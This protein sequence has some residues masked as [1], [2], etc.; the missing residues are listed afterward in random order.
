MIPCAVHNSLFSVCRLRC[1]AQCSTAAENWPQWRGPLG[2][3]VAAE[4]EYPVKFS[5]TESVAW[6]AKLPG[7]GTSTPAVWG[8]RIFVTCWHRRSAIGGKM[9][10]DAM[11]S[12]CFDMNGKEVVAARVW[13]RACRAS[14][15]NGSGSNPSPV[16][17]G[18]HVV[19]YYK[20]GTLA[21]LGCRRQG[22]LENR[23]C[24]IGLA[25]TRCGGT[26]V[27]RRCWLDDAA[28]IVAV[29]QDGRFVSG[30]VRSRSSGRSCVEGASGN[31]SVPRSRIKATRHRRS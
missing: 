31:T 4:G 8:D 22:D 2:T 20:T 30:G 15:R 27:R 11:A 26:W 23:I 13:R 25:R 14:I 29:M 9:R 3:G 6:K 19:V 16:T 5:A 1:N 28:S 21:C 17:D 18:K 24:K 7:V 10:I 12:V